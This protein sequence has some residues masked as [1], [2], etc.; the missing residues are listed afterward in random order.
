MV[1]HLQLKNNLSFTKMKRNFMILNLVLA[2]VVTILK[3]SMIKSKV[4]DPSTFTSL[5]D[6]EKWEQYG[7]RFKQDEFGLFFVNRALTYLS[8]L[9]MIAVSIVYLYY[10][11][12][13]T[14]S[15]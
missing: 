7:F 8:D 4:F 2:I 10:L 3:Y 1:L 11:A 9:V 13:V 15:L 5:S 12:A 6:A 14:R